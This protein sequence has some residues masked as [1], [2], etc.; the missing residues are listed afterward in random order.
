[1][2][3]DV[4]AFIGRFQP[5]H[6]GHQVVVDQAL[7]RAKTVAIVIGSDMSARSA[8]NPFTTEERI[9]MIT[10]VYPNEVAD[11]RIK[12]VTQIDWAYN[13]DRWV[14]GVQTGVNSVAS[15]MGWTDKP[16]KIG[17]I[18]HSKDHTSFYLK[19]FPTWGS[20][21]VGNVDGIDATAIREAYLTTADV[22]AFEAAMPDAVA[23]WLY[24]FTHTLEYEHLHDEYAF[25]KA[26]RRRGRQPCRDEVVAW[27]EEHSVDAF[28]S[29]VATF[30]QFAKDFISPYAPTYHTVDAVVV[31]SGHILL[32]KRGAMPGQGLWALPGGFLEQTEKTVDGAVRELRE[33][34]KIAVPLPV[35]YGSI[36]HEKTRTFDAPNRSQRGRTLTTAY[37]FRLNDQTELPKIK[38]S[39]DAVKAVWVPLSDLRRDEMFEDHY[40][41]ITEMVGL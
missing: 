26:Y 24:D 19:C 35:L 7:E 1:M 38:G 29:L 27:L 30:E 32:V 36:D 4:L 12:F 18:G 20:I 2:D 34:T 11:G 21:E 6:N 16:R 14:A 39:D 15:S 40:D 25:V 8:R 9:E 5:F 33:E 23:S 28:P 10:R 37:M 17:L 3:Y 13:D 31:Q 41:I 22:A